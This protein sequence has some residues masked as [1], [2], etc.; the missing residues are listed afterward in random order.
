M[1]TNP[2][3]LFV[4]DS[5]IMKGIT[6]GIRIHNGQFCKKLLSFGVCN[7]RVYYFLNPNRDTSR[8]CM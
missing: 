8:S 2:D 3:F 6:M 4:S 5:T 7:I 1:S